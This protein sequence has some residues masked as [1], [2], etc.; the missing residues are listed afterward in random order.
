MDIQEEIQQFRDRSL[1]RK[2][3]PSVLQSHSAILICWF[4]LVLRGCFQRTVENE[5]DFPPTAGTQT[6]K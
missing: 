6:S 2:V 3:N 5:G 4:P 1:L